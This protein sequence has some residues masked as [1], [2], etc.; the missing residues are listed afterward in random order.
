MTLLALFFTTVMSVVDTL[1]TADGIN[2]TTQWQ[3]YENN[4]EF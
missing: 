4:I 1:V 3:K 2:K